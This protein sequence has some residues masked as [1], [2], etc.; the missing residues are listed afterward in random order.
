MFI[1]NQSLSA[2]VDLELAGALLL[3]HGLQLLMKHQ[4]LLVR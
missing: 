3:L 1:D 4:Q 2:G